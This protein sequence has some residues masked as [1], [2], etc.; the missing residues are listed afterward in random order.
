MRDFVFTQTTVSVGQRARACASVANPPEPVAPTVGFGAIGAGAACGAGAAV[1]GGGGA[2]AAAAGGGAGA[3]AGAL[4]AGMVSV[5]E[6]HAETKSRF[7]CPAA[8]IAAL[9]AA[10]SALHCATV[11]L[12]AAGAGVAAG[13]AAGAAAAAGVSGVAAAARHAAT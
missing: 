1:A 11:L 4:A 7:V 2:G 6:R 13:G 9:F 10:Y 3:A 8:L 5:P 12:P